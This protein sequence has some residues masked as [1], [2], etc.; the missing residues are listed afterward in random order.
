VA[1]IAITAFIS[2]NDARNYDLST[3]SAFHGR[4]ESYLDDLVLTQER[5][6]LTADAQ[7]VES[8][9]VPYGG[10]VN[11]S[12]HE[13]NTHSYD[14][15]SKYRKFRPEDHP[16]LSETG[17][18][19]CGRRRARHLL[20]GHNALRRRRLAA[21]HMSNRS[22]SDY[23]GIYQHRLTVTREGNHSNK[24]ALSDGLDTGGVNRTDFKAAQWEWLAGFRGTNGPIF[25]YVRLLCTATTAPSVHDCLSLLDFIGLQP[26][27]L[28]RCCSLTEGRDFLHN[29]ILIA[30]AFNNYPAL[31]IWSGSLTTS[32]SYA[33]N[34]PAHPLISAIPG[35]GA[36]AG[37]ITSVVQANLPVDAVGPNSPT[38]PPSPSPH[39]KTI[40]TDYA[41]LVVAGGIGMGIVLGLVMA[42]GCLS[43]SGFQFVT[44]PANI[45]RFGGGG[46]ATKPESPFGSGMSLTTLSGNAP[47]ALADFRICFERAMSA[48]HLPTHET[49]L[50]INPQEIVLS[51]I[52]GEGSFGRVWNGQW[53][54]NA[55]AV[56]EFVFAQAAIEGGSLQHNSIIEEIVGEA[57]IMA[58]LRHPK[59]LQLYGCSLTMQAIWIVSELCIRGSLRMVLSHRSTPLSLETKLTLC[60]DIADGMDYL[61]SRTPPIIHRDLKS[62]NIFITETSQGTLVAKIGDWGSARAVALSSGPK[63]MTQGVGTACWL[64]PEVIS[65]A[66]FS[67]Y[68]DVYAFGIILWEV[69]TRQDVYA[70]LSAAQIIS[71]VAHEGLRPK[72][73]RGCPWQTIMT[74]CWQVD[75]PQRPSFHTVLVELNRLY[76]TLKTLGLEEI[77]E[78]QHWSEEGLIPDE[79]ALQENSQETDALIPARTP[80]LSG[81]SQ[82]P[83]AV[84]SESS[85]ARLSYAAVLTQPFQPQMLAQALA[86]VQAQSEPVTQE[87]A[88]QEPTVSGTSATAAEPFAQYT[89][90][91]PENSSTSSSALAHGSISGGSAH[92]GNNNGGGS[93]KRSS[94]LKGV[95]KNSGSS[96]S[97]PN[98]LI[99]TTAPMASSFDGSSH[100]T[101]RTNMPAP[102][103]GFSSDSAGPSE[104][105]SLQNSARQDE[106]IDA[107]TEGT[108]GGTNGATSSAGNYRNE[109]P[110]NFDVTDLIGP[111]YY[112]V[113]HQP[114]DDADPLDFLFS[115]HRRR[116][117]TVQS[118]G[119]GNGLPPIAAAAPQPEVYVGDKPLKPFNPRRRSNSLGG[120]TK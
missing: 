99:S 107:P 9:L 102:M 18:Q 20:V 48:R 54:N 115:D 118:A 84:S 16:C 61:H 85:S 73:P 70:G 105:S 64:S 90:T 74:N 45:G 96:A 23:P 55:V 97:A 5:R 87:A 98:V 19:V 108:N 111:T 47:G 109:L 31:V 65:H 50:I 67:K 91:T 71:K 88:P 41:F 36:L 114:E 49:L 66:H 12:G 10:P 1:R 86:Q 2:E 60:M 46:G 24:R 38:T 26:L 30:G 51:R 68:S 42:I 39:P 40:R 25:R 33:Y 53:R 79:E 82:R 77:P 113:D 14:P 93:H 4:R 8:L 94:P 28:F 37:L 81:A 92:G 75:A 69:Y 35:S 6:R 89:M 29:T 57:G 43:R 32:S 52:I 27:L 83:E 95:L 3:A 76:Q 103:F 15:L 44:L 72:I 120:G 17:K 13:V 80:T 22:R 101:P 116:R 78:E 112:I 21:Q 117:N 119:R 7:I 62:L 110:L 11:D 106:S 104:L 63:S 100:P 34:D 56:K 58:C 59:I